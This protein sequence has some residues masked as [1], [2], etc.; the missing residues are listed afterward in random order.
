MLPNLVETSSILR[1]VTTR[2]AKIHWNVIDA[3]GRVVMSFDKS[4]LQGQ[5]D[6]QLQLGQLAGGVYTLSG[7]TDKGLT[8]VVKFV[9]Q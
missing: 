5:N 7:T 8:S 3:Q 4:V 6:I 9:K 2:S 1:V